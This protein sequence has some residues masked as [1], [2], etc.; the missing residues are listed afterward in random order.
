MIWMVDKIKTEI[1]FF[2]GAAMFY[3]PVLVEIENG[4][5]RE[6]VYPASVSRKIHYNRV[7]LVKH[8]HTM[9]QDQIDSYVEDAV[10][11]IIAGHLHL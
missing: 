9:T 5:S 4:I 8:I 2:E 6:K 3:V 11:S 1:P 10:T 7:V